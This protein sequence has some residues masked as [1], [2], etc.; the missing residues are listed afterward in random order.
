MSDDLPA[1]LYADAVQRPDDGSTL[2]EPLEMLQAEE[3][4]TAFEAHLT[5]I[6]THHT[7]FEPHDGTIYAPLQPARLPSIAKP[8]AEEAFRPKLRPR[9]P[10][11]T[12]LDDGE[13]ALGETIRIRE[14]TTLIGRNEGAVR[15]PNDQRISAR[16]AEIVRTEAG[17]TAGWV[18]RDL[19]SKTGTFVRCSGTDLRPDR[20]IVLGSRRFRFQ[21]PAAPQASGTDGTLLM[22]TSQLA[23]QAAPTLVET[24][25]SNPGQRLVIPLL[26]PF[27]TVGRP[28]CGNDIEL[29]DPLIAMHHAQ[30]FMKPDGIWRLEAKPSKNGVWVQVRSIGL[31][32]S[33]RFQCGEQRFLF[34]V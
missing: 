13:T 8:P 19:D 2:L 9:V 34:V 25:N 21:W 14:A 12:I 27:L 17:P 11:L 3:H 26:Q 32:G 20:L 23:R 6:E 18:L 29:D 24:T 28:R 7:A 33:C 22:D 1:D 15:L 16:H 31:S 5:A 30:I 10:L 4:H